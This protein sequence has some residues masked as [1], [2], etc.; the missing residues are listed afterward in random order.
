MNGQKGV[1]DLNQK[2]DHREVV[3]IVG[4]EGISLVTVLGEV[5]IGNFNQN[6]IKFKKKNSQAIKE[7]DLHRGVEV[8]VEVIVEVEVPVIEVIVVAEVEIEIGVEVEV[9]VGVEVEVEVL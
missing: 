6:F 5:L 4:K 9:E 7:E 3:I 1:E 2:K 8:G